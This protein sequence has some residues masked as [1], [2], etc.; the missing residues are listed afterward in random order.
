MSNGKNVAPQPIE[1]LLK[2]SPLI[3]QAVLIGDNR[4]FISALIYPNYEQVEIWAKTQGITGDRA[5]MAANDKVIEFLTAE[6]TKLCSDL[7]NYERVK[8]IAL[9][10]NELTQDSGELTPTMKVK[11]RIVNEKFKDKIEGMYAEG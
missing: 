8:K 1:N 10:E 11:R 7:S 5:S 2:G 4:N 3:E 6:V 9:L